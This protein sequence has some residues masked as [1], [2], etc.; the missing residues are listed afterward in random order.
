MLKP[1]SLIYQYWSA[2]LK[3]LYRCK[4]ECIMDTAQF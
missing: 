2:F 1:L 3:A 4:D